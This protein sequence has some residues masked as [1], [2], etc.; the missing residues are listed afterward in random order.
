VY[1]IEWNCGWGVDSPPSV[2]EVP[3]DETGMNER[4]KRRLRRDRKRQEKE[5]EDKAAETAEQGGTVYVACVESLTFSPCPHTHSSPATMIGSI[6]PPCAISPAPT[7]AYPT[8]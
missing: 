4:D 1:I 8:S 5:K 7:Q 2:E 3:I 6:S